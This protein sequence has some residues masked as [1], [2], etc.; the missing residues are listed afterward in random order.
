MGEFSRNLANEQ[1]MEWISEELTRFWKR[2]ELC[3]GYF[4]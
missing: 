3:S 1:S 4:E 2:S